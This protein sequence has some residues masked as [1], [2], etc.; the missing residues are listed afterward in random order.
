MNVSDDQ[1]VVHILLAHG[2]RSKKANRAFLEL[3]ERVGGHLAEHRLLPA[4]WELTEPNLEEA[5]V[6]AV[7]VAG[8]RRV[9]VL[10]YFLSDGL[11]IRR[12]IPRAMTALR[13]RFPEVELVCLPSLQNDPL[14]EALLVQRLKDA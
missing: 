9:V 8:T 12:D 14:L 4:F 6:H 2:S 3:V 10:P 5:V 11:H 1:G 13:E 7:T